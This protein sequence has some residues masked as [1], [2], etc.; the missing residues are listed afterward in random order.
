MIVIIL[1]FLLII[2]LIPLL[3]KKKEPTKKYK[4]TAEM[5]GEIGENKIAL[6]KC[7]EK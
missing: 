2:F 5:L 6:L 1:L 7:W 3:S 4:S